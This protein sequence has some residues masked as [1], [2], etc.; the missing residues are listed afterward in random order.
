MYFS[1]RSQKQAKLL[2][3]EDFQFISESRRRCWVLRESA[4]LVFESIF[5]V[6]VEIFKAKCLYTLKLVLLFHCNVSI[7]ECTSRL[8]RI[9]SMRMWWNWDRGFI[10]IP[11]NSKQ[12]SKKS[13][14]AIVTKFYIVDRNLLNLLNSLNLN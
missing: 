3:R 12:L 9:V 11:I 5:E 1:K 10:L 4:S 7:L 13:F 8:T 6:I 14:E 2:L